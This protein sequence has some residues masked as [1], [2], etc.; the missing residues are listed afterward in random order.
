MLVR[1]GGEEFLI[2]MPVPDIVLLRQRAEQLRQAIAALRYPAGEA[3]NIT[4]S[5]GVVVARPEA[6]LDM[7]R[8]LARAD[9]A[10]YYATATCRNRVILA[11]DLS[12]GGRKMWVPQKPDVAA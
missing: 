1:W 6:D 5:F 7:S 8:W 9:A 3:N 11:P 12:D 2:L 4:G 10:L